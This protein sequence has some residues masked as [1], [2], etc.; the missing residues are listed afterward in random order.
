MKKIIERIDI[1]DAVLI[2]IIIFSLFF[3]VK[4][5]IDL[6]TVGHLK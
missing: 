2:P 1:V 5:I 3:T 6:I 4:V